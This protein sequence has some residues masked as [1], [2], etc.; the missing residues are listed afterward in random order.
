MSL[1][2]T[3]DSVRLHPCHTQHSF[4]H[5]QDPSRTSPKCLLLIP[6]GQNI[7]PACVSLVGFCSNHSRHFIFQ[8][9]FKRYHV[10][11]RDLAVWDRLQGLAHTE[12]HPQP[13]TYSL[14][15][16]NQIIFLQRSLGRR[17]ENVTQL[18]VESLCNMHKA[19]QKCGDM[20]A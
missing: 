10:F 16:R 14:T 11:L 6:L 20:C 13:R 3:R 19:T 15:A 9:I 7:C 18:L 8:F 5:P 2:S 1:I 12:R 17:A 4:I